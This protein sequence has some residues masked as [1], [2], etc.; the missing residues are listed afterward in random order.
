MSFYNERYGIDGQ[1]VT[2]LAARWAR[3][4]KKDCEWESLDAFLFWCSVSG[5]KAGLKLGRINQ[6][7]PHGPGNSFWYDVE[8]LEQKRI[9]EEIEQRTGFCKGCK[10]TCPNRGN[11]CDNWKSYFVKNWNDNISTSKKLRRNRPEEIAYEREI[12]MK[13]VYEHPDL[14]REGIVY[15]KA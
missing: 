14:V 5:H 13:F 6:N 7:Q 4:I 3:T 12:Q 10:N 15:G 8:E 11:G 2:N 1:S 9:Q